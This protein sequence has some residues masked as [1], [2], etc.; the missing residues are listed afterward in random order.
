MKGERIRCFTKFYHGLVSE[1]DTPVRISN[2][3]PNN[4]NFVP[5]NAVWDTGAT[6]S[7][8]TKSAAERCGLVPIG[9]E[10]VSGVTGTS[11]VS[12]YYVA[13]ELPNHIV[14]HLRVTEG[15]DCIGCDMLIGMDVISMGDFC[16]THAE[17]N[18]RFTFRV[19]SIA[20]TDYV[21]EGHTENRNQLKRIE[22][23]VGRNGLCPCGSG[24]K[25]KKCCGKN[26]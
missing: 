14:L 4:Q 22:S 24:K 5:V 11:I 1:L 18:T 19:P 7:V 3:D 12:A 9:I 15:E 2:P 10:H 23:S 8:I 17:D 26:L 13:V 25:F 20:D 6:N 16:I 21:K